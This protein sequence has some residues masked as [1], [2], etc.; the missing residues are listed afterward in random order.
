M[1]TTE[2][3]VLKT[4]PA[5]PV[6]PTDTDN[7][8]NDRTRTLLGDHAVDRLAKSRVL[9]VGAG[10]V[11]GYAAEMLARSGVGH[12]TLIDA[13]NVDITN[14]NRQIIATRS[15][16][17]LP[18]TE[19]FISRFRD[20]NPDIS[21]KGMQ[22]FL[23][24]DNVAEILDEG[25][26]YIVDAIDTVAPKCALI[27]EALRR[28]IPI[29]SSMGAGGRTDPTRVVYSDLWSTAEDG[30][31]RAVRQR[32]KKNGFTNK[33]KLKVVCSTEAP[34]RKAIID[35]D[36]PNKRS[37]FGTLATIPSLFG[38]FLAAEVIRQL[39]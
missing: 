24:S 32:L 25:Y 35:L 19:L 9:I 12:L 18:K 2:E 14:I 11:G 22:T 26:D 15:S 31:A 4:S 34:S 27:T 28:K 3:R 13:D 6:T 17:G 5:A 38:I 8:W 37:S 7:R 21:V 29:I 30:L 10:G 1:D 39:S 36:L 16:V 33:R 20:I 23:T